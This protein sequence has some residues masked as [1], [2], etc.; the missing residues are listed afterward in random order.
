VIIK[1]TRRVATLLAIGFAAAFG[2]VAAQAQSPASAPPIK[3]GWL[4]ALTGPNSSPGI[5][6]DRGI[7]YAA[8]EI[9]K[10]GGVRGRKIEVIT[11]DTQGDPTKAVNAAL[12]L[13]NNEHVEFTVGPT[14]SGEGLAT[15][16]VISRSKIPSFVYG[17]VDSLIDPAKYP[18]A[19]RVSPANQDWTEATHAY[20]LKV[21]KLKKV[22]I[23]GDATGYGTASVNLSERALKALGATVTYRGLVEANQTDVTAEMRKIK[24]SGAEALVVWTDSAGLNSRLMNARAEVGW[25]APFVGHPAMGTGAVKPLLSKPENWNSV[26]VIGYRPMSFDDAG[27]LPERSRA[28]VSQVG[29]SVRLDDTTL[30]WVAGGYDTIQLIRHVVDTSGSSKADDV[31]RVLE[32]G[33]AF[34][35]VFCKCTYTPTNHNGYP[36]ADVVMNRADSFRTGAYTL[37][38]GYGK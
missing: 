17:V 16:P 15:T 38:P 30:W 20:L 37:A 8:E 22:G 25:N 23:I 13:I 35:G 5:G 18:Y 28:F 2:S 11:R 9:N 6:F 32:S 33:Q 26:Y 7:K 34:P 3:V 12:E 27:K 21:L 4:V 29:G 24:D 1:K 36:T 31:K 14:N 10:A 19:F